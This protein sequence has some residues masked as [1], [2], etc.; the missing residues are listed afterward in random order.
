MAAPTKLSKLENTHYLGVYADHLQGYEDKPF[1]LLEIGI[2]EGDSLRY[3]RDRYPKATVIGIDIND[4]PV[5]DDSGRIH[6][7]QGKQQDTGLLDRIRRTHAPDGIDIVIDDGSHIG[8]YTRQTF[9]HLMHHHLKPGGLYFIEDWGTGYW[10]QYEDGRYFSPRAVGPTAGEKLFS[11]LGKTGI[12]K[13]NAFLSKVANTLEFKSLAR[14]IPSHDFGMVGFVKELVDE[15]G[16]P[17]ATDARFGR[18]PQRA[19]MFDFM[20]ISVGHVV[21]RKAKP[22]P[23]APGAETETP[24]A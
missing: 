14:R 18:S 5:D 8:H 24:A 23:A 20:Q 15:A 21:I 6:T 11:A 9:W 12:V 3:W 2:A 22:K 19:S 17:D 4:C 13:N 1:T 10:P 16:A 7:Y